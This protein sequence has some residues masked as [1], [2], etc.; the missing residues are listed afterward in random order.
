MPVLKLSSHRFG[1]IPLAP[2]CT[3]CSL[4]ILCST[5]YRRATKIY[6]QKKNGNLILEDP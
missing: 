1:N 2:H 6:A 3:N 5:M 4:T